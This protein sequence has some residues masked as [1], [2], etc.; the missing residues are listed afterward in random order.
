[1]PLVRPLIVAPD[2]SHWAKWID[3]ALK[4]N[5]E[6]SLTA[7]RFHQR[8]LEA[9]RVPFLSWHHL[10]EMLCVESAENAA[11]RV[12]YIQKLPLIA[13]MQFPNSPGLGAV[14]DVLAA[15]A[16][17]FDA[18]CE[19]VMAIRDHVKLLLMRTGSA[20]EAVGKE[21][22]VWNVARLQMMQRRPRQGMVTALSGLR[23]LDDTQT[24]GELASKP[25]RSPEER[26]RMMRIIHMRAFSDAKAADRARTPAEASEM[27]DQFVTEVMALM[28]R[29]IVEARQMMVET[30]VK[31]GLDPDEV[32][33]DKTISELSTLA[34]F[35]SQLRTV[36]SKSNLSFDRLKR[37]RM[38]GLPSWR[39]AN[40]LERFGQK[41]TAQPGS[42]AHDKALAVLAAYT[43]ILYV[44]KRTH[45]DFRQVAR[46]LPELS[47]LFGEIRKTSR[48]IDMTE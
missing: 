13:W 42:D 30:Y 27:A 11:A 34:T 47:R 26:Q 33:D 21:N 48:Y 41:R 24:F 31:Q 35:R 4:G 14:T 2:T 15:E 38:E 5:A 10:E 18:G 25:V 29:N 44:D 16:V 3:A 19:D 32:T 28:P 1:M 46:K 43:D 6:Q 20:I 23:I 37:V 9:G 12:A 45:E 40:A 8:L 7:R 17:A 39:I 22:W 36:A